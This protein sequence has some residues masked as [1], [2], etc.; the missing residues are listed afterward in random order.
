MEL[1][2]KVPYS[3]TYEIQAFDDGTRWISFLSIFVQDFK[4][5]YPLINKKAEIF[6]IITKKRKE[7]LKRNSFSTIQSEHKI[8]TN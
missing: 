1:Q 6:Q 2:N 3:K 5:L 7:L 4:F 8:Y